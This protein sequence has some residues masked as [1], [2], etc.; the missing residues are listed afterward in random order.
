MEYKYFKFTKKRANYKNNDLNNF[1]N[2]L[3]KN[4]IKKRKDINL[5]EINVSDCSTYVDFMKY[6]S[7]KKGFK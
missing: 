2:G 3:V 7:T 5:K 1:I 4:L 6:T